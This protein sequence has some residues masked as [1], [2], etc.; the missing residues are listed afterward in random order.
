[1]QSTCWE[2][3]NSVMF[4]IKLSD[5]LYCD[6]DFTGHQICQLSDGITANKSS[7]SYQLILNNIYS[8]LTAPHGSCKV[9][10][11]VLQSIHQFSICQRILYKMCLVLLQE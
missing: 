6:E 1:M 4:V 11:H 5:K 9:F 2:E 3:Q 7:F 8:S 10:A